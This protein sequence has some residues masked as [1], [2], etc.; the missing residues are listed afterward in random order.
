MDPGRGREPV[1]W[2]RA[3]AVLA[4]SVLAGAAGIVVTA[5]GA[6]ASQAMAGRGA[7]V[8]AQASP[9]AG[10]WGDA[11]QVD[12]SALQPGIGPIG[13]DALSCASPGNCSAG[14]HYTDSAQKRQAFV[15]SEDGGIWGTPVEL[16]SGGLTDFNS[17]N[18]LITSL[19]CPVVDNCAVGG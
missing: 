15:V 8:T 18:P 2:R 17:G 9:V 14:G 4:G 16:T 12:L 1:K 3:A 6:T 11:R 19:T 5:G 10:H 13:I 7:A